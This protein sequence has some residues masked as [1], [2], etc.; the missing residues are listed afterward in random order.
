[1]DP[2]SKEKRDGLR[3]LLNYE[4]TKWQYTTGVKNPDLVSP[5]GAAHDQFLLDRKGNDEIQLVMVKR[6]DR[7]TRPPGQLTHFQS[8]KMHG[9]FP[10]PRPRKGWL[11][12]HGTA[13]RYVRVN[14]KISKI[15][16]LLAQSDWRRD[17]N[18]ESHTGVRSCVNSPRTWDH[19]C[20]L[21]ELYPKRE[22]SRPDNEKALRRSR[23][24]ARFEKQSG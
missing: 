20:S 17:L 14:S 6:A 15:T 5:D 1:M 11:R 8:F 18:C 3:T 22:K 19:G 9:N 2:T 12:S 24:R 13:S 21:F 10:G 16:G 7:K 4:A 23:R